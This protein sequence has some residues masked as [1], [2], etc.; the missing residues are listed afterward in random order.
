MM[1][2][3]REEG[4]GNAWVV[5]TFEELLENHRRLGAADRESQEEIPKYSW[6]AQNLQQL[7]RI[8]GHRGETLGDTFP[9]SPF[10]YV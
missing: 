7:L 10:L 3:S 6:D 5:L 4:Q 8:T 1:W 2:K 9:V